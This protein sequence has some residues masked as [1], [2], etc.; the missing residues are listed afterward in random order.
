MRRLDTRI[1]LPP[2]REQPDIAEHC[3]N[4]AP[5]QVG[6]VE[7]GRGRREWSSGMILQSRRYWLRG[8]YNLHG[9]AK[10]YTWRI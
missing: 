1:V 4:K 3:G 8:K 10:Y 5:M 7:A 2:I 6:G 9:E